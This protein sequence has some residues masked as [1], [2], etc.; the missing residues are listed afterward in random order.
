M[1][2]KISF[3]SQKK[4]LSERLN[5]PPSSLKSVTQKALDKEL[6]KERTKP[7]S[8]NLSD[9][10]LTKL[11]KRNTYLMFKKK[12]IQSQSEKRLV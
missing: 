12:V 2:E 9:H 11:K 4:D 5:V 3:L 10:G 8:K 6:D 7:I 1:R